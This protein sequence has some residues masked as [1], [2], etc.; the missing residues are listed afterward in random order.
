[1][2]SGDGIIFCHW[3]TDLS[4]NLE[5]IEDSLLRFGVHAL[6]ARTVVSVPERRR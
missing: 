1:M 3:K 6:L 4:T 5:C 2:V